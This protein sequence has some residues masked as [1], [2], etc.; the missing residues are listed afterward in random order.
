VIT[1]VSSAVTTALLIAPVAAHRVLFQSGRK[2]QLVRLVHRCLLAGLITLLLTMVGAM[3]LV[4]DVV[5]RAPVAVTVTAA[6]AAFFIALWFALPGYRR[7][8]DHRGGG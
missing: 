4:L 7:M 1:L 2:R 3:L 5:L 8:I 6:V